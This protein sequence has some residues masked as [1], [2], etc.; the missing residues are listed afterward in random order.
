MY[1]VWWKSESVTCKV[2]M[3]ELTSSILPRMQ[4]FTTLCLLFAGALCGHTQ[5]EYTRGRRH[6]GSCPRPD[7]SIVTTLIANSFNLR[8]TRLTSGT[9]SLRLNEFAINVC[10]RVGIVGSVNG[11]VEIQ[12]TTFG[13]VVTYTC[14]DTYTLVGNQHASKQSPHLLYSSAEQ[15]LLRTCKCSY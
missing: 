14:E 4:Q 8:D 1:Q 12:T 6:V 10:S 15:C 5:T 9:L 2:C 7:T 13:S 11:D 3:V